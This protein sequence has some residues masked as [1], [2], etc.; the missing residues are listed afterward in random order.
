MCRNP[1]Y[2]L[3]RAKRYLSKPS[4]LSVSC[5]Q[6]LC[7]TLSIAGSDT[8]CNRRYVVHHTTPYVSKKSTL[9]V[10]TRQIYMIRLVPSKTICVKAED[11]I[12][13]DQKRYVSEHMTLFASCKTVHVGKRDTLSIKPKDTYDTFCI[14]IGGIYFSG[15]TSP[16]RYKFV[17][18]FAKIAS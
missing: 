7:D 8:C 11:T 17:S 1:R 2:A 5:R 13:I 16:N 6:I 4:I 10:F 3:Y 15:D 9:S 18:E 14:V 12:H